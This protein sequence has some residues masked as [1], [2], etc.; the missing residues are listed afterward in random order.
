MEIKDLYD[1]IDETNIKYDKKKIQE[2][3]F[4]YACQTLEFERKKLEPVSIERLIC[5][6]LHEIYKCSRDIHDLAPERKFE[7]ELSDIVQIPKLIQDEHRRNML[8]SA[9]RKM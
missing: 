6:K 2:W 8:K 5:S 3:L 4:E 1:F 9:N 7:L